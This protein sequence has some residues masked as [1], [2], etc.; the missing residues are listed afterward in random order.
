MIY[1]VPTHVAALALEISPEQ[2]EDWA[3]AGIVT[4]ADT[5][6]GGAPLWDIDTLREQSGR[7]IIP[8]DND[9]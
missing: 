8:R 4:P 5:T 1:L 7:Q 3:A 9:P 2:L 6:P